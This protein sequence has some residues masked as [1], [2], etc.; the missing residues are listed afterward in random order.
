LKRSILLT[1]LTR[2]DKL[3]TWG[4]NEEAAFQGL[5][6]ECLKESVLKMFD[7]KKSGRMKTDASDLV[8]DACFSQLYE[9]M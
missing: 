6:K 5:K 4:P 7:S 8:I 2:K 9:G 1:N 3:W